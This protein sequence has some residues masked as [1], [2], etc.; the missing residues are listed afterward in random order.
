MPTKEPS[1][2]FKVQVRFGG[3]ISGNGSAC[4]STA[5]ILRTLLGQRC[6]ARR[7][8]RL[9]VALRV[10]RPPAISQS[11]PP[12][13]LFQTVQPGLQMLNQLPRSSGRRRG[14][15]RVHPVGLWA[16]SPVIDRL[17]SGPIGCVSKFPT[18]FWCFIRFPR[19]LHIY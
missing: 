16:S 7:A 1:S 5:A 14:P 4:C 11:R 9:R 19:F 6:F 10:T 13:P 18:F 2:A 8:R 12:P 3:A 17:H 15:G